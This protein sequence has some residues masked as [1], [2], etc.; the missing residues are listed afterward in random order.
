MSKDEI[1]TKLKDILVSEFEIE[2]DSI[3][4]DATLFD[5]L[6]LDSI[7]S[8]D[9]IQKMKEFMPA[10]TKFDPAIFKTVK[11]V[12]DVVDALVPYMS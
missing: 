1:F 6:D 12:Q 2:E 10:G 8:I 3:T 11:T 4:P 5:D 7:D 9:L